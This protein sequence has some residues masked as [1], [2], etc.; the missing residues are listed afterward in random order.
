[1]CKLSS[2]FLMVWAST[3][4]SNAPAPGALVVILVMPLL[5]HASIPP[6]GYSAS[7]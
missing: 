3:P 6:A 5:A 1:M 7:N 4:I 2:G